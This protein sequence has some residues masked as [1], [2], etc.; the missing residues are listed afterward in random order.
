MIINSKFRKNAGF[1]GSSSIVAVN[2]SLKITGTLFTRNIYDVEKTTLPKDYAF[3]PDDDNILRDHYQYP[4]IKFNE[5]ISATLSAYNYSR[6]TLENVAFTDNDEESRIESEFIKLLAYDGY[7]DP[8]VSVSVESSCTDNKKFSFNYNWSVNMRYDARRC[9]VSKVF[10]HREIFKPKGGVVELYDFNEDYKIVKKRVGYMYI[11]NHF[12][13]AE[14]ILVKEGE[15]VPRHNIVGG[16]APYKTVLITLSSICFVVLVVGC[17]L[18]YIYRRK[19]EN[20]LKKK[21]P[22]QKSVMDGLINKSEKIEDENTE[23]NG[24]E[25]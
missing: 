12:E 9:D 22:E 16:L 17:S 20:R 5:N 24:A 7:A 14:A 15:N 19:P 1:S 13:E 21:T 4:F 6:I 3:D 18:I 10:N 8:T 25:L 23:V 11:H 2:T